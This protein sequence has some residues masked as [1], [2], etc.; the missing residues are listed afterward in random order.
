MRM[1]NLSRVTT[2]FIAIS[3]TACSEP[4]VD[5]GLEKYIAGIKAIDN[6]A[7]PMLVV[8]KGAPADTDY[9]ALPLD[10]IPP[11]AAP[12]R[13][14]PGHPDWVAAT[15]ATKDIAGQK[16]ELALDRAGI[17][18]MLANRVA[19]G[20]SLAPPRFLWVSFA[21]PLMLPLDGKLE[22][23]RTPDTRSLYALETK[24]LRRYMRD[25]GVTKLPA[26]LDEYVRTVLTPTLERQKKAGA[27]AVKF[28]AAYLR[29]L[30]FDDPDPALARLVYSRFAGGGVPGRTEYKA[31]QDYLFR[32]IAREAGRLGMSVHIH[33]TSGAGSFY[34]A[35]GADPYM[36]ESAMN[37]STL[38]GTSFV[39]IHGG[40]PLSAQT[41]AMMGRGKVY[42]DISMTDVIAGPSALSDVLRTWLEAWPERVLF[43][44]D[45]FDGGPGQTWEAGAYLASNL[46]RRSLGLA[47]TRM[48]REGSITRMRAEELARMVMRENALA[49]YGLGARKAP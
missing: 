14:R 46:A 40:W 4:P 20:P 17:D 24:L 15:N 27:V 38:R 47:L 9:D 11:G 35:R 32:V 13:L 23:A 48:M 45:A 21:D 39:I 30:D 42:A 29:A 18:I 3:L 19:M 8:A 10:A 26:S 1:R 12:L 37:D 33:S 7:H 6:H 49:L 44:T 16:T 25:L 41:L 2:L 28:E 34:S 31:L 5:R 22:S 36:L 43:G